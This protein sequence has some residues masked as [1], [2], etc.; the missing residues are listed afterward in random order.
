[1]KGFFDN[2]NPIYNEARKT[3]FR[4]LT[5]VQQM[6]WYNRLDKD[7]LWKWYAP[8]INDTL[9]MLFFGTLK[10]MTAEHVC[11]GEK[12]EQ[13]QND[14]L[15]GQGGVESV[16]P[17]KTLMEIADKLDNG[18]AEA[19]AWFQANEA[20][21]CEVLTHQAPMPA[22][23][24]GI[25]PV[26]DA[27]F[28]YID[29][30]GFRCVNELKL[31][32]KDFHDDPSFVVNGLNGYVRTKAYKVGDMEAHEREIRDKAEGVVREALK[33][34]S[35]TLRKK[36]HWVLN[37]ARRVVK[38][39]ENL[40]FCRTK[41]WGV[42]RALFRGV[43]SNLAAL[44]VIKSEPDVFYLS[45]TEIW[46]WV[47]GRAVSAEISKT[48]DIRR[49]EF[50]QYRKEPIPPQRFIT[51]GAVGGYHQYQQV[52][53]DMDM[54]KS[55][56]DEAGSDPNVLKGVSCCPGAVEGVC[57][58]VND[59]SECKALDGQILVTSRTDPGWVPL[60]P[61]C[62]GLLIERGSLLSHS[63]VVAREIG[64]PTIVG[65]SG[66]LMK[67]L[68]TGMRVHV[69]AGKGVIRILQGSETLAE[70]I[71]RADKEKA[72]AVAGEAA[73]EAAEAAGAGA[74]A[75][76]GAPATAAAEV[77]VDVPK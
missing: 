25:K 39:R 8:I 65:I 59:I 38:H 42:L 10:K 29:R 61:M 44:N 21:A 24:E 18:P 70:A 51:Y 5:L 49:A 55:L 31:E 17:T 28:D 13:L 4:K 57:L 60:Y 19:R 48:V 22:G 43:G 26:F 7:I 35:C 47:E 15:T 40:R 71:A 2:F 27:L 11:P 62:K 74:G 37:N 34:K 50:D 33:N 73:A 14:L 23:P 75:A 6:S 1:V 30:F 3:D 9:V 12:G 32:E 56:E 41:L 53:M 52:L 67:R 63:A 36:Y 16:L 69:D 54:L 66:G 76:A 72:A 45:I 58:V 64:L 20:L 77:K 68:K 46:S